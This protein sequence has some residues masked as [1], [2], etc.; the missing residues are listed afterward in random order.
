M[1]GGP[2]SAWVMLAGAVVIGATMAIPRNAS[3]V[4]EP[5][6][7]PQHYGGV[8]SDGELYVVLDNGVSYR[9]CEIV[10]LEVGAHC[11]WNSDFRDYMLPR[12]RS[13]YLHDLIAEIDTYVEADRLQ[14][15]WLA[16]HGCFSLSSGFPRRV[17]RFQQAL[18]E[19]GGSISVAT[20][21]QILIDALPLLC[22]RSGSRGPF[23]GY[24]G[25]NSDG[26]LYV[27][28]GSDGV[29]YRVCEILRL[30]P[31]AQCNWSSEGRDFFGPRVEAGR[32]H[33]L[34]AEIG[35]YIEADRLEFAWLA[36]H[37]CDFLGSGFPRRIEQFQLSMAEAGLSLPVGAIER[38]LIDAEPLLCSPRRVAQT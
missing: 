33:D 28:L 8:T 5:D 23:V 36:L 29:G 20:I 32:L 15:A 25:V 21:E 17:A 12:V 30:E 18:A 16:L 24:G 22:Q 19:V 37:S 34:I 6:E 2:R 26:E 4:S 27:V 11:N 3:A 14:L 7:A 10:R 35:T 31:G 13:G 1:M 9:F 38:I